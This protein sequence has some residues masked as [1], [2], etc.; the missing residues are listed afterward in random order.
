MDCDGA[1][2]TVTDFIKLKR[3]ELAS[4]VPSN[5]EERMEREAKHY[6]ALASLFDQIE[7]D[8][9][10]LERRIEACRVSAKK[11]ATIAR[12]S[13]AALAR[14]AADVDA[15]NRQTRLMSDVEIPKVQEACAASPPRACARLNEVVDTAPNIQSTGLSS[16]IKAHIAAQDRFIQELKALPLQGAALRDAVAQLVARLERMNDHIRRATAAADEGDLGATSLVP[17]ANVFRT[18]LS[19]LQSACTQQQP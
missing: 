13:Q 6:E 4:G 1:L 5:K 18:T 2:R 12:G 8:S 19:S 7:G 3:P 16:D 17:A 10:A 11:L 15:F 9:P 14:S